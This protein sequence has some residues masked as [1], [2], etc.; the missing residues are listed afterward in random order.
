MESDPKDEIEYLDIYHYADN[1]GLPGDGKYA[2]HAILFGIL[3]GLLEYL[4]KNS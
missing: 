3:I 1:H 4:Y 2:P